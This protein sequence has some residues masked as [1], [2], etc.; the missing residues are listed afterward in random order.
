MKIHLDGLRV[1]PGRRDHQIGLKLAQSPKS[2]SKGT[3]AKNSSKLEVRDIRP[4]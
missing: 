2:V 1:L 3:F 4:A